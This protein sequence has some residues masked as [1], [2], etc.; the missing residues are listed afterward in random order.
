MLSDRPD[1][2]KLL[3]LLDFHPPDWRQYYED[4]WA[5]YPTLTAHWINVD[6]WNLPKRGRVDDWELK[7][8]ARMKQ[9]AAE[10]TH[11]DQLMLA[12]IR[13]LAMAVTARRGAARAQTQKKLDRYLAEVGLRP[14]FPGGTHIPRAQRPT[15]RRQYNE[16]RAVIDELRATAAEW[17]FTD[18][19]YPRALLIRFPFFTEEE[20]SLI[21]D[22]PYPRRGATAKAA[23][24]VLARRYKIPTK[25]LD[26]YLFPR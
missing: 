26:R 14:S 3:E 8:M 17:D 15:V 1:A 5:R 4:L 7:W 19:N 2:A 11:R 18:E 12:R 6:F 10:R 25:T 23:L 20:L 13:A 16:L 21:F 24:A 9:A 22:L